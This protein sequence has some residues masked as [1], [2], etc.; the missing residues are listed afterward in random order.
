MVAV[1]I[2][3]LL[4]IAGYLTGATL[5]AMF[6]AMVLRT[7]S[8]KS[9]LAIVTAFL[10]LTW[11]VG[12]LSMHVASSLEH[13]L[14]AS[15]L[16]AASYGAL[17]LL[18]AVVVH[19]VSEG[20]VD[21]G[22]LMRCLRRVVLA[23]AYGSASLATVVHGWAAVVGAPLPSTLGLT[24]NTVGLLGLSVPLA[25][26]TR[27]Q[28]TQRRALW[29]VALAAFGVSALHVAQFHSANESWT[30]ELLGHHASIPLAFTLLYEDYR[31]ALADLFLK[32]A[33]TLLMVVAVV[34]GSYALVVF[35]LGGE[36]GALPQSAVAVLLALWCTTSLAFPW[37]RRAA[38]VFVDR[39]VLRR[40]DYDA[41]LDRLSV[42]VQGGVSVDGVL[43]TICRAL[44][45]ALSARRV[46]WRRSA[47][48]ASL[49]LEANAFAVWTV[50]PPHFVLTVE[51]LTGGRRLLSDDLV[52]LERV[53]T[54]AAR[55]IDALRLSE[56]RYERALR[57]RE[58]QT[59]ATEAELRALR[60]QINPHFLFNALTTIGYLIQSQSPRAL[61]TLLR[62][63]TLLRSVLRSAGEFT[64]L[65]RERELVDCY[66]A[67][68]RERFEERL[69]IE[70]DIPEQL[71]E[72]RIPSLIVQ[73]LV[74][75]AVT[76]GIAERR[77][78]GLVSI[79]ARLGGAELVISVCNTDA[80]RHPR[81]QTGRR[82]LGLANVE[83]RL[84]LHY[85]DA[86]SV[87]LMHNPDG[88]TTAML[89]LPAQ[90]LDRAD[91]AATTRSVAP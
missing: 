33:L 34:V 7:R 17:G 15:W 85:G 65:G 19:S 60:A 58:I 44:G 59:L 91:V 76:H 61:D 11:N 48:E 84:E 4:H 71:C 73:P 78:R 90:D 86:A 53:A 28:A 64:T 75:N 69:E 12:E 79:A 82:G 56:E 87:S 35:P 27:G 38:D 5:Y 39:V 20:S 49:P 24:I 40:A 22:R 25:L 72:R 31:F 62:L 13:P 80:R 21:D 45:P 54:I 74:E 57:E 50:E 2:P 43:T 46:T 26:V 16:A 8:S 66:L 83:R 55:R 67:I 29:M 14:L 6:L 81:R 51:T 41:V 52:L 3:A 18:A 89:R 37:I 70:L 77:G 36:G 10:G 1:D 23:L 68:E 32:H 9:R 88:T 30:M 42:D 47:L 63:T